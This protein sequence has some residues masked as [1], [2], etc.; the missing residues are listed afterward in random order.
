MNRK[1]LLEQL[2]RLIPLA[3]RWAEALEGRILREGVSL[4]DEELADARELGVQDPARV[5]L[6]CLASAPAPDDLTLRSVAAAMQVLTP[7]TRGL[8]LRY[9]IFVRADCWRER[10]LI[11]HELAHTAQYERFGGIE[12]F[13]QQYLAEYLTVGYPAGAMEQEAIAAARRLHASRP[14]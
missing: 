3:A 8:A 13:L 5:R 10:G 6:L 4:N 14:A 9:G 2:S 7:T 1:A 12:P 11:A